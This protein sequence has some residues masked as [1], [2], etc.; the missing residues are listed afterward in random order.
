MGDR[1]EE[2]LV[3]SRPDQPPEEKQ[4]EKQKQINDMEKKTDP[5]HTETKL[6]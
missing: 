2:A 3:L 1:L 4:T 5:G 6:G